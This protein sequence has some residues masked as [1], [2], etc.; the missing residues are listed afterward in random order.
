MRKRYKKIRLSGCNCYLIAAGDGWL[1]MDCGASGDGARLTGALRRLKIAP[2]S[3]RYL[4]LSHHHA[5]H[6]GL[7][8]WLDCTVPSLTIIMSKTCASMLGDGGRL[9]YREEHYATSA[10]RRYYETA[11]RL[12]PEQKNRPPARCSAREACIIDSDDDEILPALGI[13]GRI[14]LN[15]THSGDGI[16]LTSG[17]TAFVGDAARGNLPLL[18][19]RHMPALLCDEPSFG[20]TMRRLS[21]LGIKRVCPGHG[22]TFCI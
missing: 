11:L 2:E 13:D 16:I 8:Q 19:G 22:G 20:R 21:S 17:S 18:G 15:K 10:L 7:A 14:M 6:C 12:H 1:M 9:R 3:I 4:V 5:G